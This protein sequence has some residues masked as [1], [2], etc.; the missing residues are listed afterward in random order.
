MMSAFLFLAAMIGGALNSVA[1]GGSFVTLPALLYSGVPPV[2]ANAT[3]TMA[4]WPGSLSSAYAYRHDMKTERRYLVLL[5]GVSIVGGLIGAL[6]LVRTSDTHFMQLLPWLMLLASVTFSFGGLAT[7]RLRRQP[8]GGVHHFAW[9]AVLLQFIISVY[10]GYFGGGMGIM[11]LATMAVVG[12][13]DIH[14]MNG[15]KAVMGATLNGVAL[16][17]FVLTG[18]VAWGHGAVMV[19]GSITGGYFG[20][21]YARQVDKDLVK[22]FVSVVAWGLTLYFFLR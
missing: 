11:M 12:M 7:A 6:L 13:T 22:R 18:A 15:L 9:W 19:A 10:G 8:V 3:S 16:A 4:L 21:H 2:M 20:A 17:E 5:V 1:G 14:E